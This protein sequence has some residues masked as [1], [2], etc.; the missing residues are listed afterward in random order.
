MKSLNEQ[1]MKLIFSGVGIL[2]LIQLIYFYDSY[3][4]WFHLPLFIFYMMVIDIYKKEHRTYKVEILTL[5]L[6]SVLSMS[7]IFFDKTNNIHIFLINIDVLMLLILCSMLIYK[8]FILFK[9]KDL[10]TFINK[11][12]SRLIE[13]KTRFMPVFFVCTELSLVFAATKILFRIS[14]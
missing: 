12:N 11:R 9:T 1:H 13:K 8:T 3:F 4:G 10:S 2:L 5:F 14:F 7:L 6:F